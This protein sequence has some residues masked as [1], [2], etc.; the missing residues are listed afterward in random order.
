MLSLFWEY[1]FA[2]FIIFTDVVSAIA[3]APDPYIKR[4]KSNK[5]LLVLRSLP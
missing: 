1:V 2:A 3:K 4:D 5:S